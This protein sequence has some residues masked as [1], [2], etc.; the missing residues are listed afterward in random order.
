M[1]RQSL[2]R[3][4]GSQSS[5]RNAGSSSSNVLAAARRVAGIVGLSATAGFAAASPAPSAEVFESAFSSDHVPTVPVLAPQL[6]AA[7]VR[8]RE[9]RVVT[10]RTG[11]EKFAKEAFGSR[12]WRLL[13]DERGERLKH[14]GALRLG[15][16]YLLAQNEEDARM[17]RE[18]LS[19][20][21]PKRITAST[22]D[23]P[24]LLASEASEA[25]PMRFSTKLASAAEA[26]RDRFVRAAEE[27]EGKPYL[28]GGSGNRYIDCSQLVV[29]SMKRLGIVGES[30]DTTAAG[31]R[32]GFSVPKK[33]SDVRYGD[34]VYLEKN[35]KTTHV[36]IALGTPSGGYVDVL[37][38][39]ST[40]GRVMKRR[41]S[42]NLAGLSVATPKFL[43][44]VAPVDDSV[45]TGVMVARADGSEKM[46]K[47]RYET[48]ASAATKV[49]ARVAEAAVSAVIPSAHAEEVPGKKLRSAPDFRKSKPRATQPLIRVAQAPLETVVENVQI[50]EPPSVPALKFSETLDSYEASVG[51]R[52]PESAV[53]VKSESAPSAVPAVQPI[54]P[55]MPAQ[56]AEVPNPFRKASFRPA[57]NSAVEALASLRDAEAANDESFSTP[58]EIALLKGALK[59]LQSERAMVERNIEHFGKLA[60]AKAPGAASTLSK[61]H[62]VA[63]ILDVR[64]ADAETKFHIGLIESKR[65]ELQGKIS[66]LRQQVR[67]GGDGVVIGGVHVVNGAS[68]ELLRLQREDQ[69]MLERLIELRSKPSR[70]KVASAMPETKVA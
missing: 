40:T 54:P 58:S 4:L 20:I 23:Q 27:H 63:G 25:S 12:D 44:S 45:G 1:N 7:D 35:G 49:V 70:M 65:F 57:P 64:I 8:A 15:G 52:L 59:K 32:K 16:A 22:A 69:R 42:M 48:V 31:L 60:A 30:F 28:L 19:S 18:A 26:A 46:E 6:T 61:L 13:I 36:A 2:L 55:A 43:D 41:I 38:A 68:S 17:I 50:S 47:P 62:M 67:M 34:F 14:A 21:E 10:K 51:P 3:H 56:E 5:A 29:E 24:I 37:D 33:R 53:P 39:S 11:V 66:D 9:W